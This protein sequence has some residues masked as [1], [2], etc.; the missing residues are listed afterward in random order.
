MPTTTRVNANGQLEVKYPS[1]DGWILATSTVPPIDGL[2]S[3]LNPDQ[4]GVLLS[5]L[6]VLQN[7][8]VTVPPISIPVV[9]RPFRTPYTEAALTAA[10][11]T[12]TR[13]AGYSTDIT[14]QIT[15]SGLGG[16]GSAVVKPEG[17]LDGSNWFTLADDS[18]NT[19]TYSANG[20]YGVTWRGIL[21]VF[22]FTLVS[23]TSG[24]SVQASILVGGNNNG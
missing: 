12:P 8:T 7:L 23:V 2:I 17:S 11:S 15:V 6:S 4:Y 14:F 18:I 3:K 19:I 5:I 20:T 13:D 1:G 21:G 22:R 10:G 24:G 9:N 16:G